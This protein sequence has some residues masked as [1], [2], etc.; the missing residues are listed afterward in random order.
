MLPCA[1]AGRFL[2]FVGG[3]VFRARSQV[4][5]VSCVLCTVHCNSYNSANSYSRCI[6]V[7]SLL[8]HLSTTISA[9]TTPT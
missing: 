5:N 4:A 8:H 9:S 3:G 1:D 2:F 6:V 7:L